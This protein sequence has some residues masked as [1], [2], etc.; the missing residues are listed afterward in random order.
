M[1]K[2][3]TQHCCDGRDPRMGLLGCKW[4]FH[5]AWRLSPSSREKH[6]TIAGQE[7]R[8]GLHGVDMDVLLSVS[9]DHVHTLASVCALPVGTTASDYCSA[10]CV[11]EGC[12]LRLT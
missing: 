8:M 12:E 3:G 9:G 10:A 1:V 11:R 5:G 6:N 4:L 7:P 2:G